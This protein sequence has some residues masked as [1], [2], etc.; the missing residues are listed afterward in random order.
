MDMPCWYTLLLG[1]LAWMIA[2]ASFGLDTSLGLWYSYL[3][4][5]GIP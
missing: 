4:T 5:G 2:E 1:Q 3:R